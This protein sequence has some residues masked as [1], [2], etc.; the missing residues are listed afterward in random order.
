ML[1]L[2]PLCLGGKEHVSP[3]DNINLPHLLISVRIFPTMITSPGFLRHW[4]CWG[5]HL[6]QIQKIFALLQIMLCGAV[7]LT[8]LL[9]VIGTSEMPLLFLLRELL[10]MES[11]VSSVPTI[12]A[13]RC[14]D[15]VIILFS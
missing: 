1:E 14:V 4:R 8:P 11:T 15:F 13:V 3:E 5:W 12:T 9:R 6:L 7:N 2:L 10:T